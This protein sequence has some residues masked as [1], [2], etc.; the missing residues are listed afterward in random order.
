MAP[1]KY[2]Y[3]SE[4]ID[5]QKLHLILRSDLMKAKYHSR[6]VWVEDASGQVCGVATRTYNKHRIYQ[7]QWNKWHPFNCVYEFQQ[8]QFFYQNS[9]SWIHQHQQYGVD[10]IGIES[11][12]SATELWAFLESIGFSVETG[13]WLEGSSHTF[14][15]L[16]FWDIF[17]CIK[18]HLTQIQFTRHFDWK[19]VPQADSTGWHI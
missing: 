14:G 15:T 12:Q 7:D 8:A 4:S 6:I 16:Y 5:P 10:D 1:P 11:L 2:F 17:N 13:S 19:L 9:K 3:D 18:V